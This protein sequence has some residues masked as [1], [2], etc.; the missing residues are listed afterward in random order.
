MRL[1]TY[2]HISNKVC[3]RP[4]PRPLAGPGSEAGRQCSRIRRSCSVD[5]SCSACWYSQLVRMV[6]LS[7]AVFQAVGGQE[8]PALQ[9]KLLHCDTSLPFLRVAINSTPIFS[10]CKGLV[11]WMPVAEPSS[12]NSWSASVSMPTGRNSRSASDGS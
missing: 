7:S 1:P 5:T 10:R 9:C 12:R 11:G 6:E 2:Q 4:V 3:G 8:T